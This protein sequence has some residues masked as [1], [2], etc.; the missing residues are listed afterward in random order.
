MSFPDPKVTELY[1]VAQEEILCARVWF[2]GARMIAHLEVHEGGALTPRE[3]KYRCR[4]ELGPDYTPDDV[5]FS[6]LKRRAA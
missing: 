3:I 1:L 4:K 6:Q 2:E 5:L